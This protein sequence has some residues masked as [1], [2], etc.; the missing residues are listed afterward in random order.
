M[1]KKIILFFFACT[2]TSAF[3]KTNTKPDF[4]IFSYNRPLQLHA[5]LES[6][7]K[8]VTGINNLSVIYRASDNSFDQAY[9]KLQK[10]FP[11]ICFFKQNT[12]YPRKDFQ[13]L[14]LEITFKNTRAQNNSE[15]VL[16]GV[17][18]IIVTDFIDL[19]A[20]VKILE[21]TDAYGFYLRLGKNITQCYTLSVFDDFELPKLTLIKSSAKSSEPKIFS[22]YFKDAPYDWGFLTSVDMTVLRKKDIKNIFYATQYSTPNKLEKQWS[23]GQSSNNKYGLCYEHSKIVNIPL[24]LVQENKTERNMQLFTPKELLE[25][26]MFGFKLNIEPLFKFDNKAP[27]MHYI[28]EF[29]EA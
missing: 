9:N 7:E 25:E 11:D 18:D 8:Y 27:H 17:D 24:N 20:C 4:V 26:F 16:F 29:I 22:W 19:T 5:Y 1:I 12:Q 3:T 23:I 10:L 21:E 13:K 14:F 28:P 15:Y 6:I 2:L